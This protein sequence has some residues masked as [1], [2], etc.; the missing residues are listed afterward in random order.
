MPALQLANIK[1]HLLPD[2]C[3]RE[4]TTAYVCL[5]TCLPLSEDARTE[6]FLVFGLV[7]IRTTGFEAGGGA[8]EGFHGKLSSCTLHFSISL[9]GEDVLHLLWE[10]TSRVHRALLSPWQISRPGPLPQ[11]LWCCDA[12]GRIGWSVSLFSGNDE[13]M[14]SRHKTACQDLVNGRSASSPLTPQLSALSSQLAAL[15]YYLTSLHR[16][17]SQHSSKFAGQQW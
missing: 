17:S 9:L 13:K 4:A 14:K 11:G 2:C 6:H 10:V 8:F 1:V 15:Q 7:C 5:P 3:C 12:I 16:K